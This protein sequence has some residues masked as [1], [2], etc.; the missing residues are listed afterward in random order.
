ME[1]TN[2]TKF[3]ENLAYTLLI[4]IKMKKTFPDYAIGTVVII[5]LCL[6]ILKIL[7]M[8]RS[9][10]TYYI[11]C[12][13]P[14]LD[15]TEIITYNFSRLRTE[16]MA[17]GQ[18]GRSQSLFNIRGGDGDGDGDLTTTAGTTRTVCEL[19]SSSLAASLPSFGEEEG[20][21]LLS[22]N[23]PSSRTKSSHFN[24]VNIDMSILDYDSDTT[25]DASER[26]PGALTQQDESLAA[27]RASVDME[28]EAGT[29]DSTMS[30]MDAVY[31]Q[32]RA[33][34]TSSSKDLLISVTSD[35]TFGKKI[36]VQSPPIG[37]FE[38]HGKIGETFH[39]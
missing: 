32:C 30:E 20:L 1:A 3:L 31:F 21:R 38:D 4:L 7:I 22:Q 15:I 37:S 29:S 14:Q 26:E 35:D 11:A 10:K 33:A 8:S 27:S 16:D 36:T 17:G 19:P 25:P 24:D 5:I 39:G 28:T 6:K 34:R 2:A 9:V 23:S 13:L 18:L 12:T